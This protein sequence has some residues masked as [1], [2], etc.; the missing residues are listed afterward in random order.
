MARCCHCRELH[1]AG[2]STIDVKKYRGQQVVLVVFWSSNYTQ[3]EED[4]PQLRSLYQDNKSK[5]FE[6]VGVSLDLEKT[7]AQALIQ[8]NKMNWPEIYEPTGPNQAGGL[9]SPIATNIRD[10]FC[11]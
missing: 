6:I 10:N 11:C 9:Y 5:G 3:C 8:K 1:L 4:V 2:D 7:A